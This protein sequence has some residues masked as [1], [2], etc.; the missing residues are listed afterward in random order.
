MTLGVLRQAAPWVTTVVLALVAGVA[1]AYLLRKPLSERDWAADQAVQPKITFAG[2]AVQVDSL[3]DFHHAPGG[4]FTPAYRSLRFDLSEVRG[5]WFALAPFSNR[6]DALAHTFVSFELEG[7]RYLAVSVEA[8]RERNESYSLLGGLLRRFEVTYVVG[9]EEDLLGLRA[10]RGDTLY[11]YPS[12]AT[13][14][15]ARTML[16]DML[17]RGESLRSTPEFY[18]TFTNNCA[19]NLRTHVNRVVSEPLP[20]GW[21]IVLPGYSDEL[22]LEHRLLATDL[23]LEEARSR[24]RVDEIARAALAEGAPDFSTRIRSQA[25]LADGSVT[26]P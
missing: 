14:Q 4:S 26:S 13:P 22:A 7:G 24:Y 21:A 23:P 2:D 16:S 15:Q 18:N 25:P 6:W 8:R 12:R 20:F 5:V 17:Q 10:I 11:L 1:V 19:T 9:T 3:R